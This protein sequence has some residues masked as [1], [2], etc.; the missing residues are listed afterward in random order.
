MNNDNRTTVEKLVKKCPYHSKSGYCKGPLGKNRRQC[1]SITNC[2]VQDT[3]KR[4]IEA[5]K[6]GVIN[7]LKD[8]CNNDPM[9]HKYF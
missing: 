9:Y 2:L 7:N 4:A 5:K 6:A 1:L 3:Y 8:Y